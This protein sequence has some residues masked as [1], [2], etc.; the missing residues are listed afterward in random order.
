MSSHTCIGSVPGKHLIILAITV[1]SEWFGDKAIPLF[2][3]KKVRT[4]KLRL[5]GNHLCSHVK[6]ACLTMGPAGKKAELV[7]SLRKTMSV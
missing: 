3:S 5:T 4:T 1:L 6:T 2:L 7:E